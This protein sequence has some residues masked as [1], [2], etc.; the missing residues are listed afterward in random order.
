MALEHLVGDL[1]GVDDRGRDDDAAAREPAAP[2]DRAAQREPVD[3]G[4]RDVGEHDVEEQRLDSRSTA[5][6]PGRRGLALVAELARA[7]RPSG[8][9]RADPDRRRARAIR[10]SC[11]RRLRRRD[12]ARPRS[13]RVLLDLVELGSA[14]VVVDRRRRCQSPVMRSRRSALLGRQLV[15]GSM[16]RA[17][18][19]ASARW[20]RRC[21]SSSPSGCTIAR[22]G[23]GRSTSRPTR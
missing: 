1:P 18:S 2:L 3:L 20:A 5:C 19:S 11:A 23:P 15:V 22:Y 13:P 10:P 12:R 4:R 6:V 7:P 8:S 21:S 16:L 9:G 14:S 17:A